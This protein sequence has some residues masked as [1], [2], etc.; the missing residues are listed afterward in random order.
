MQ[1]KP[2]F[3]LAKKKVSVYCE[4][5]RVSYVMLPSC[6]LWLNFR[7]WTERTDM[8]DKE[9]QRRE[10]KHNLLPHSQEGGG[11]DRGGK[12]HSRNQRCSVFI[13]ELEDVFPCCTVC[14]FFSLWKTI[15]STFSVHI[16]LNII[17][18]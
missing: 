11:E 13:V 6:C 4:M 7:L 15:Y 5:L 18:G 12:K 10:A 9:V 16:G 8:P 3:D 17:K 14:L 2:V 1:R